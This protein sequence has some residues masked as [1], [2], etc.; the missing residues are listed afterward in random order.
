MKKISS[1][2]PEPIMTRGEFQ[3]RVNDVK[4]RA[5]GKWSAILLYLGLDERMIVRKANMP[6]PMCEGADRFQYTDKYGEGNYHC[7][8]CGP[9]GGFKLAK[10]CTGMN[11]NAILQKVEHYLGLHPA[12]VPNGASEDSNARMRRLAQ[13]VWD[14]AQPVTADNEAGK[15][16]ANRGLEL[17]HYPSVLRFHPA[18]DYYGEDANGR[19]KKL[20]EYS[21]M[22]ASIQAADGSMV[23][24]HRT[25]LKHCRKLDV[26]DAKK[27]LAAGYSGAAIRLWTPGEELAIS[28][29][30]EKSIAVHLATAKPAWA[31]ISAGN[32]EKLWIPETVN[33]I[34]IYA[35]NNTDS[36]FAGQFYAFA[37]A[38]RLKRECRDREVQVFIP[39]IP[40]RDWDDIWVQQQQAA[41]RQAA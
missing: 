9:G 19:Q 29:G 32:L 4:A 40:G 25:Y 2:L 38:R 14:E 37:L 36:D 6:C 3:R 17:E 30:I 26:P 28:E 7:R 22:L 1:T 27:V 11:F 13:R 20:G 21:A 33:K 8:G 5:H 23:A 12:T 10:A 16:L 31:A 34:S 39:S 24:L 41:K 18:L 15:H 35:D